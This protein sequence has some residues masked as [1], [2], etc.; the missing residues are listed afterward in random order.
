MMRVLEAEAAALVQRLDAPSMAGEARARL[1]DGQRC[2][3]CDVS[4][5][6]SELHVSVRTLQ[7]RLGEEGTRFSDAGSRASPVQVGR[8]AHGLAP[9]VTQIGAL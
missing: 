7:C 5:M 9:R 8:S 6:A 3:S 2:R 4:T 1:R